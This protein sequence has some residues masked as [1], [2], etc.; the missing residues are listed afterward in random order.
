MLKKL[1]K[2]CSNVI[3]YGQTYCE[4]CQRN[5]VQHK[6][7]NQ[8]H[9]DSKRDIRHKKFYHSSEWEMV[10]SVIK[11]R[12]H[13]VCLLCKAKDKLTFMDTV[14]HIIELKASW[15][16]RLKPLNLICLCDSCHKKVHGAY[17]GYREKKEVQKLLKALI[18]NEIINKVTLSY[19]K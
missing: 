12:D 5:R 16:D 19:L 1:C 3:P 4:R 13:G 6:K 18:T 2:K 8:R 9:H 14:H 10:R 15:G 17:K 7:E 11:S